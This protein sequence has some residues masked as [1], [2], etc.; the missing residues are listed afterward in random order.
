MKSNHNGDIYDSFIASSGFLQESNLGPLFPAIFIKD[1]IFVLNCN[2]QLF[3]NDIKISRP[4]YGVEGHL[5]LHSAFDSI[6]MCA[7]VNYPVDLGK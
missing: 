7:D 5:S 4:V 2:V 3:A 6:A 1:I